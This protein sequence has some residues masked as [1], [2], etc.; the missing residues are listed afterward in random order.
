M[1]AL[2]FKS[3]LSLKSRFH[4]DT[5]ISDWFE[6]LIVGFSKDS[7][8]S[9]TTLFRPINQHLVTGTDSKRVVR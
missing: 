3:S 8:F 1:A 5:C 4:Q 7:S 2:R 6:N 9:G